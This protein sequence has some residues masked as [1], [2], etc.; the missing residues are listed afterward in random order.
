MT[1][2]EEAMSKGV[3]WFIGDAEEQIH[4]QRKKNE[5]S[6]QHGRILVDQQPPIGRM[7]QLR[8]RRQV[9]VDSERLELEYRM[10]RGVFGRAMDRFRYAY[11]C[12]LDWMLP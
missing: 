6:L 1:E 11:L 8:D 9:R 12:C 5:Y 3:A 10:K 4:I 7:I 2:E